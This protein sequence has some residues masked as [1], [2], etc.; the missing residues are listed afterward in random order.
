MKRMIKCD[1]P[2][3]VISDSWNKRMYLDE[4]TSLRSNYIIPRYG[5]VNSI[6]IQYDPTY[7]KW[8]RLAGYAHSSNG[9]NYT[10]EYLNADI[11]NH[12]DLHPFMDGEWIID[13]EGMLKKYPEIVYNDEYRAA[14]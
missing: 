2:V 10:H 1:S 8:P 4:E 5:R 7:D 3:Q 14:D 9:D 11:I 12:Y 13:L 6:Y